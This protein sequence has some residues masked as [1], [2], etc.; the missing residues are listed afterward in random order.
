M[1]YAAR[2]RAG[3]KSLFWSGVQ[4]SVLCKLLAAAF[5]SFFEFYVALCLSLVLAFMKQGRMR[6]M[7][8][9]PRRE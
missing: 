8:F 6:I 3:T 4:V 9:L 5:Y 7:A 2:G 1:K